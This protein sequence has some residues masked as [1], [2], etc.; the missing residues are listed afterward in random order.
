MCNNKETKHGREHDMAWTWNYQLFKIYFDNLSP[1]VTVTALTSSSAPT[2]GGAGWNLYSYLCV[3]AVCAC[4]YL[5]VCVCV[6]V[7]VCVS[8]TR[9]P[10]RAF[11]PQALHPTRQ[12]RTPR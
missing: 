5:S 7:C 2:P 10:L 4:V 8:E 6:C 3:S 9:I 12:K 11:S 1:T